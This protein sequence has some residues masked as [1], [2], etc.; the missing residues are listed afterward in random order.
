M[1]N[2]PNTANN[3]ADRPALARR[4][5]V[6]IAVKMGL[7]IS[8]LLFVG[9]SI[10][11]WAVYSYQE[12]LIRNQLQD[13]SAVIVSQLAATV[14]EPLFTD[15]S[16]EL[17]VLLNFATQS[18]RILGA[19]VYDHDHNLI[20]SAGATPSLSVLDFDQPEQ[21]ID[22]SLFDSRE[23]MGEPSFKYALTRISPVTFK[24]VTAGYVAV[25]L[26]ADQMSSIYNQALQAILIITL[27]LC[28]SIVPL[29]VVMGKRM[30][31]PIERLVQATEAIGSG[32]SFV[33]DDHRSDEI[34]ELIEAINQMGKGLLHKS[35]VEGR[36]ESLLSKD[37]ARKIINNIDDVG[38]GGEH[39][40]ATVLFADIVGF[41]SLS[42]SMTP[43]QVSEFLN[44][45]FNYLNRCCRFYFGTIDKYIGD[46][47]MVLFGAPEPNE[48]QKYNAVACAVVM[49]RVLAELNAIREK[50]GKFAVQ[51]R[52]G[53]N[54]GD[55]VAGMIGSTERMEYT[56]V[57]DAVNLAS[58][59][60]S[61]AEAG[62]IVIEET[63]YNELS[64]QRKVHV[65][66]KRE[67]RIRGK[68]QTINIYNVSDIEL[69]QQRSV[70]NLIEDL[71]HK[72]RSA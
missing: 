17:E 28:V 5:R 46:C 51:L 9:M 57:G 21:L 33:I 58:R 10:L 48:N 39:V 36:L 4:R 22:A 7:S 42:E 13:Y 41:T 62:Q 72:R 47:I 18:D 70:E 19:A 25:T 31:R 26:P 34:G 63:L 67:I 20:V 66:E 71:V 49:Q 59:L 2:K 55:M 27:L 52:I 23:L 14:T 11:A 45:F 35:A 3:D 43:Q 53:I 1:I 29:A 24:D 16:L 32:N 12:R 68:S 50:E 69:N 56:V 44:E 64:K 8:V 61:E 6:P 30:S 54:S 38:V 60:C 15:Q 37:I 65:G 40:S